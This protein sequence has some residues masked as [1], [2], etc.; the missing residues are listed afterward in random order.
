MRLLWLT[1][2]MHE[3]A[4]TAYGRLRSLTFTER[5]VLSAMPKL[6]IAVKTRKWPQPSRSWGT[7]AAAQ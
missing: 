2:E 3:S 6:N 7:S 4:R 5:C 1:E